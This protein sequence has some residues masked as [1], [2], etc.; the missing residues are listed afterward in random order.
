MIRLCNHLTVLSPLFRF[1]LLA[2][3]L[4]ALTPRAQGQAILI[5]DRREAMIDFLEEVLYQRDLGILQTIQAVRNPF[6]FGQV[7]AKGDPQEETLQADELLGLVFEMIRER[8]PSFLSMGGRNI[9]SVSELGVLEADQDLTIQFGPPVN[10]E[11]VFRVLNISPLKIRLRLGNSVR[12]DF[13]RRPIEGVTR[14]E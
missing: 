1:A 9:L 12:E 13:F 4:L 11:V 7:L 6:V 5:P 8:Q 10:E 14:S 3:L 2:T